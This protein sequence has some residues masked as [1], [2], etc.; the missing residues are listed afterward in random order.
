MR[1]WWKASHVEGSALLLSYQR[2][3]AFSHVSETL[4][5]TLLCRAAAERRLHVIYV[6]PHSSRERSSASTRARSVWTTR[7]YLLSNRCHLAWTAGWSKN[8]ETALIGRRTT[9]LVLRTVRDTFSGFLRSL[10]KYRK[11]FCH[12][13]VWK[14]LE[15]NF[16]GPLVWKNKRIFQLDLLTYIFI[17]FYSRLI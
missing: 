7:V 8:H 10:E 2:R 13:P 6:E 1:V 3:N 17:I 15:K 11:M 14:S 4:T 16:F 5:M 12:F 9:R